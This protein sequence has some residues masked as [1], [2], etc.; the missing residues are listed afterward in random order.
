MPVERARE[1][2]DRGVVDRIEE[3]VA[4]VLVGEDQAEHQL[5]SAELPDGTREGAWLRVRRSGTGLIVLG[6]D[7]EGEA[8]QRQ[9]IADRL[10]RL[11]QQGRSG[12]FS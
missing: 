9:Q 8:R 10:D 4:V 3:G 7:E 6:L 11:R 1:G 12:R 5:G 2:D